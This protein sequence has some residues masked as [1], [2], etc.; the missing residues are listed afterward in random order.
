MK[1]VVY[2]CEILNVIPDSITKLAPE[3]GINYCKGWGDHEGMG[4]SVICAYVWG[5][6]YRVF[7]ADNASDFSALAG[8]DDTILVGFN[9]K[10]F[11]DKLIAAHFKLFTVPEHRSWDLLREFRRAKGGNPD[12]P[13][14]GTGGLNGLALANFLQGKQSTAN[15]PRDWQQGLHGKVID[16]CLNDVMLTKKL[17]E[18]A[19]DYRLRDPATGRKLAMDISLLKMA[20]DVVHE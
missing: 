19:L 20:V 6:G 16:Q 1:L 2:D 7:M 8:S 12:A 4:I 5:E 14:S 3:P 17:V 15:A 9:N 10:A 13:G 18:L 11:D